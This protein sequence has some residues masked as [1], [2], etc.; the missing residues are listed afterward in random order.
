M[1]SFSSD[2]NTRFACRILD[3]IIANGNLE[4]SYGD[5]VVSVAVSLFNEATEDLL[6]LV[7]SYS[8]SST[9]QTMQQQNS[10]DEAFERIINYLRTMPQ[11]WESGRQQRVLTL[12][13]NAIVER[14]K[15][16]RE[17]DFEEDQ[18]EYVL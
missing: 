14:T 3:V 13:I 17:I 7:D 15:E 8:Y 18:E 6:G 16:C 1:T 2:F 10:D 5:F 9:Q 4:F 12:A 11:K